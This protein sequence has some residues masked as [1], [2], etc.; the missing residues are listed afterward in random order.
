VGVAALQIARALGLKVLGTAGTPKGL[1]L[2]KRKERIKF[3]ITGRRDIR[4]KFCKRP[5]TAAWT[6]FWKCSRM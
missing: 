1:E 5:T 4:K 2:A 6:S 3:S